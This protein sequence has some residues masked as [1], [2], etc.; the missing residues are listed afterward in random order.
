MGKFGQLAENEVES[1]INYRSWRCRESRR[2]SAVPIRNGSNALYPRKKAA[3]IE[4]GSRFV[5]AWCMSSRFSRQSRHGLCAAMRK[6]NSLPSERR[7]GGRDRLRNVPKPRPTPF[8]RWRDR[9]FAEAITFRR[10]RRRG[11]IIAGDTGDAPATVPSRDRKPSTARQ[12]PRLR[13]PPI[14]SH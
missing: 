7:A 4:R 9:I 3:I 5:L 12:L 8:N 2:A 1:E 6:P 13:V 10:S 14:Q 11:E